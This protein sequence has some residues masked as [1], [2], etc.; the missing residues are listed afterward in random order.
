MISL[1]KNFYQQ[2]RELRDMIFKSIFFTESLR[3][4][5]SLVFYVITG[6]LI[7]FTLIMFIVS[8]TDK[9]DNSNE[10]AIYG[11]YAYETFE[12]L[13]NNLT[14]AKSNLQKQIDS[15]EYEDSINALTKEQKD[16]RK[17]QIEDLTLQVNVMNYLYDNKIS[18]S[19]AAQ[20]NSYKDK[21]GVSILNHCY[22]I[23][24]VLIGLVTIIRLSV[25][26]PNEI[27]EGQAKLTLTLPMSRPRYALYRLLSITVQ[28]VILFL[29]YALFALALTYLFYPTAGTLIFANQ[30]GTFGT[31]AVMSMLIQSA[32]AL[33]SIIGYG[34]F[35][36]TVSLL[37]LN[38][39]ATILISIPV[40]FAGKVIEIIES[41]FSRNNIFSRWFISSNFS[42]QQSYSNPRTNSVLLS[43]IV[44]VIYL[45]TLS[46]IALLKFK[47]QDIVN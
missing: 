16:F 46:I 30:S 6:I 13:E 3:I 38:K 31:G 5:K 45:L 1:K 24:T 20:Y 35:A 7:A 41:M 19:Q 15:L 43:I 34:V 4:I 40:C 47:R 32:F 11:I 22:I 21:S 27:K 33:I 2:L 44:L 12:Q 28:S 9:N 39:I 14:N 10:Y 26:M 17:R 42:V 25:A 18:F 23:A 8:V 37:T 29:T 36:F